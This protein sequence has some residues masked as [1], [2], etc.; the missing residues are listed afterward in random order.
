M[1]ISDT[2]YRQRAGF[3]VVVTKLQTILKYCRSLRLR[4][5]TPNR[6]SHI[7]KYA[8][9]EQPVP[10]NL[11]SQTV[12]EIDRHLLR[13][14]SSW[15]LFA[16]TTVRTKGLESRCHSFLVWLCCV[17][18]YFSCYNTLTLLSRCI[19]QGANSP[20]IYF[21]N[22]YNTAIKIIWL[23]SSKKKKINSYW[24]R[25]SNSRDCLFIVY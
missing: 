24:L 6:L 1:F 15:I 3:C 10:K 20:Q 4:F 14:P 2:R 7:K 22:Y 8:Q 18:I 11:S 16:G 17:R 25:T 13:F 23:I 19:F 9:R 12:C 5:I 21:S